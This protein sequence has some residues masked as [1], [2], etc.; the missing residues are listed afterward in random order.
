MLL[1]DSIST[2]KPHSLKKHKSDILTREE[3]IYIDY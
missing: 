2:I 1:C 3:E